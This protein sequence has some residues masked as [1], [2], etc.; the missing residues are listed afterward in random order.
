[1]DARGKIFKIFDDIIDERLQQQAKGEG[2]ADDTRDFLAEVLRNISDKQVARESM[3]AQF[4]AAQD[5]LQN[6]LGWT[7]YELTRNSEWMQ[8]MREESQTNNPTGAVLDYNDLK[9]CILFV[10]TA[11]DADF[12][13]SITR[14]T[15][16]SSTRFCGYGPACRVTRGSRW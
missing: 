10:A 4:F 6:L 1:M 8:R 3:L 13:P 9:A 7:L 5:N 12:R 15:L 11:R 14:S 2:E 16:L